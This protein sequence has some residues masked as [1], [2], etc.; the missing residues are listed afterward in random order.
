MELTELP[1]PCAVVD[2][3]VLERNAAAMAA[4]SARLGV[5][6]RPHVKT[7]KCVEIARLQLAGLAPQ[8]T[9]STL[10]EARAF[11]AGGF[12]DATY[13][14]PLAPSRASEAVA[15]VD[16][17]E[18][19]QL[20]VDHDDAAS[21]LEEAAR[22]RARRVAVLLKVDCGYHRAGVDP[23][24][25]D[26]IALARR[27]ADSPWLTLRGILTHAGHAY[28]GRNRDDL[29]AVAAEER[30]RT[31]EF[32]ERL[33]DHGIDVATVSVGSTPTLA[34]AEHLAGVTEVRPGNYV[35]FDAFQ[36]AIGSCGRADVAFSVIASVI[37][38]Y[39]ARGAAV[40]DAGSLAL[41]SD[42]GAR[43]V[44]PECGFGIVCDLHG[45]DIVP[46]LR[47]GALS[48]EHGKIETGEPAAHRALRV[49]TK[50]RI[51]PNHSCLAAACFD[52]YHAVRGA[53]VVDVWRP[54]KHW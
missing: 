31:V 23:E 12:P 30:D 40:L 17:T 47:I 11:A 49:G 25:G 45:R 18:R 33:R 38:S 8:I 26:S 3:D 34:V 53:A 19:L 10:A 9:V 43:H 14:V 21:A 32:A 44:D 36:A 48:Q 13:A 54:V 5:A 16:G 15:L 28:R 35:F 4:R 6:L 37:G 27:I 29:R 50:V 51:L 22:R 52:R 41:S 24:R 20:V 1:T 7:H 2:L 39:P 46:G 42:P